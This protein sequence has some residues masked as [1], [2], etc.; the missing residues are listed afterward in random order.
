MP[1]AGFSKVLGSMKTNIAKH[2]PEILLGLGIVGFG[3]TVVLAVKATPKALKMIDE[4]KKEEGVDTLTPIETVKVAWKPYL[5]AAISGVT[6]VACLVAANSVHVKRN[7]AIAAAYKISETALFEYRDKVVETIGEKKEQ[8]VR[9]KVKQKQISS[10]V[11][12]TRE[13]V[14]TG[15]GNSLC[16]DPLSK[17]T[18]KSDIEHIRRAE[19][20]LNKQMLHDIYGSVSLNEFYDEIGLEHTDVGDILG[21]NTEHLINLDIGSGITKDGEP[22][23]VISHY[24]EPKYDY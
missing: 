21:W 19:N 7:A 5:P 20:A 2:S 4:K 22:C 11:T 9:D 23:L 14:Y 16:L 24:N 1:K 6:S 18:F 15:H 3:T 12:D 10:L 13:V 8:A 17:R